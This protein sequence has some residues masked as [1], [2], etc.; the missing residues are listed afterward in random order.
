PLDAHQKPRLPG[1]DIV[2]PNDFQ[3]YGLGLV[4][5]PSGNRCGGRPCHGVW[6]SEGT[7]PSEPDE[8]SLHG[9]WG[10]AGEEEAR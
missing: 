1:Q 10:H 8:V 4:E 5:A 9:P 7:M 6:N 3:L 2:V